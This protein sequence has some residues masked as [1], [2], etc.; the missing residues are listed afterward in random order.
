MSKWQVQPNTAVHDGVPELDAVQAWRGADWAVVDVAGVLHWQAVS[1]A[2]GAC[3]ADDLVSERAAVS[4]DGELYVL[5]WVSASGI[6]DGVVYDS[7]QQLEPAVEHGP[8]DVYWRELR[9]SV[10]EQREGKLQLEPA[11]SEHGVV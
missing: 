9:A 4:S 6:C 2:C 1:V 7:G 5:P 10:C 8:T 11:A 3:A